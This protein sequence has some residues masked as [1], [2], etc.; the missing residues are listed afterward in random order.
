M[1][2]IRQYG[3]RIFG[4]NVVVLLAMVEKYGSRRIVWVLH[5]NLTDSWT[6]RAG[7]TVKKYPRSMAFHVGIVVEDG[8][9]RQ[10]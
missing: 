10:T 6:S 8:L 5:V 9:A 1:S 3:R 7:W 4:R 2:K